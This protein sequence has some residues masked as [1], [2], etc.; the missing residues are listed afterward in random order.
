MQWPPTEHDNQIYDTFYSDDKM[1]KMHTFR[2][3]PGLPRGA[4]H[5]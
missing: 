1:Q 5:L 3:S 2:Q 4:H